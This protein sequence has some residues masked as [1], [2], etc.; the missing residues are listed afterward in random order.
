MK[1]LT[2][3][4]IPLSA[5]ASMVVA[6]ASVE[7]SEATLELLTDTFAGETSVDRIS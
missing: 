6:P 1:K 2:R 5:V 7:A 3:L 4:L